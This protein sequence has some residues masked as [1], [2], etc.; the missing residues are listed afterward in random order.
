MYLNGKKGGKLF[1]SLTEKL[2]HTKK[3]E[4]LSI[5]SQ[6]HVDKCR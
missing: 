5:V 3:S 6:V 4:T 2:K 1:V